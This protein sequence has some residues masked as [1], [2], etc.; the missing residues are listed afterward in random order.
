MNDQNDHE[1]ELAA[2]PHVIPWALGEIQD[3]DKCDVDAPVR[4]LATADC[5]ALSEAF[6]KAGAQAAGDTSTAV[7]AGSRVYS[8]LAGA[9]GMYLVSGSESAP[10]REMMV[11]GDRRSAAP[12]DFLAK[13]DVLAALSRATT[14][15]AVRA[16]LSDIAW[17]L[18]R[19][20]VECGRIAV[21]SYV[22]LAAG[23][24]AGELSCGYEFEG[25]RDPR[26]VFDL[27]RRAL[28]IGSDI[29][30]DRPETLRARTLAGDLLDR[31]VAANAENKACAAAVLDLDFSV[32]D[33]LRVGTLLESMPGA[34]GQVEPSRHSVDFH[35]VAARAWRRAKNGERE[36]RRR[37]LAAENFAVE[38]ERHR[39]SS[40]T[41]TA[42]WLGL[43]IAEMA[44]VPGQRKRRA[45]LHHLL[46]DAQVAI[47]DEMSTFSQTMDLT[48]I[49]TRVRDNFD[50][51][52]LVDAL[53]A[54]AVVERSPDPGQLRE[55]AIA[56]MREHPL[57]ALFGAEHLD[58]RG[59][60]IHR[61]EAE[62]FGG[63]T[64]DG[65]IR[66]QIEQ[67]ECIRRG[68][69]VNGEIRVA[70]QVIR[71][72][73]LLTED[74]VT[75][76]A[77]RSPFVPPHLARTFG[78]GLTHFFHFDPVS[79]LYVL[80]PLLETA[81]RELLQG[82]GCA[83]AAFDDATRIQKDKS[84]SQLFEQFRPEL[85]AAVTPEI[86]DEIDRLFLS[87][88][89]PAFRHGVAHGLLDDRSANSADALYACW[90]LF[91]LCMLP[92]YP[93]RDGIREDLSR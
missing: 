2:A 28:Q 55:R 21:A 35:R 88:P 31:A 19:K 20:Q 87:R 37:L 9:M 11:W 53:F 50:R 82:R 39:S 89:G 29:G 6:A 66:R 42:H 49:A 72:K 38:A 17:L 44:G 90:F 77:S 75:R 27:V 58:R 64:D 26:I 84:L 65:A 23:I 83:V 5:H 71:A 40:S 18:D 93:H 46:I 34:V 32:S 24:I 22:D 54:L 1:A 92:L 74:D 61:T 86:A 56:S 4:E 45:E 3:L 78:R 41:M 63:A 73:G 15:P 10:F 30:W 8:M 91:R 25:G 52:D 14:H 85:D 67:E 80:T 57:S 16:R 76:I 62:S 33:P 13:V 51:L 7:T 70:L 79:A 12:A 47:P 81:I 59:R 43:A 48:E 68:I 69:L 60:T 36:N